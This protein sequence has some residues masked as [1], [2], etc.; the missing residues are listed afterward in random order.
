MSVNDHGDELS[1]SAQTDASVDPDRLCGYME[2]ALAELVDA[3]EQNPARSLLSID[4]LPQRERHELL[5]DW[6]ATERP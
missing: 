2:A 5:V 6:N 3:L 1:L 4:V